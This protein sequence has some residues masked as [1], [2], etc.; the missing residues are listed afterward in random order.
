MIFIAGFVSKKE[1]TDTSNVDY[2]KKWGSLFAEFKNNKGFLSS[3][4]YTVHFIR[5]ISFILSQVYLNDYLI[6]QTGLNV[7]FSFFQVG[8]LI[9]Y[10][11]F[12]ELP[13]LIS[14]IAGEMAAALAI[15]LS[16]LFLSTMSNT[17][18]LYLETVIIL[19]VISAML[20]QFTMSIAALI[21]L[22]KRICSRL[23][24]HWGKSL[25]LKKTLPSYNIASISSEASPI[26]VATSTWS[27]PR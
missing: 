1:I 25:E 10:L 12:K 13:V 3:Q 21:S 7:F 20:V 27:L 23:R 8:F 24:K 5:R 11:P 9:F 26:K 19:I 17:A 4:Y 22:V 2:H 6:I 15:L 18:T 16:S 14:T